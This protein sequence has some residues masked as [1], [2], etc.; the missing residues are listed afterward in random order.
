VDYKLEG[1]PP[2]RGL[3]E[4]AL[5]ALYRDGRTVYAFNGEPVPDET[6]QAIW[7]HAQWGPTSANSQPLRVTYCRSTEARERLA[8]TVN[9]GNRGKILSAGATALLAIDQR[10]HEHMPLVMPLRPD[11]R[12]VW[13][14]DT[15]TRASIGRL[16]AAIQAGYFIL[17][18][19][20]MGLAAGPFSGFEVDKVNAEF[21]AGT[22]YTAF[23]GVN[24]GY[25]AEAA[26]MPRFPRVPHDEALTWL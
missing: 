12:E 8:D 4:E 23:M 21:F 13:E 11:Y 15:E 1:H 18:V 3:D 25:P 10:F 17:A 14:E 19:R 26:S 2:L 5:H 24:I 20:A 6:L 16:S 22:N 7:D 9:R